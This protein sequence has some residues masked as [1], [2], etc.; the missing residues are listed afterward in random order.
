MTIE[1]PDQLRRRPARFDEAALIFVAEK[2]PARV[3]QSIFRSFGIGRMIWF[4]VLTYILVQKSL[5]L[6]GKML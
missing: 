1:N 6:F 5:Q 4:I 3:T 2:A